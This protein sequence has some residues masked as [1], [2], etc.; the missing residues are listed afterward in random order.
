MRGAMAGLKYKIRRKALEKLHKRSARILGVSAALRAI[1]FPRRVL[2][3]RPR[4]LYH[5]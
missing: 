3:L 5:Y 4:R 1:L 2:A